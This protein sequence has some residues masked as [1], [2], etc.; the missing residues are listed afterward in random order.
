MPRRERS[1]L[2]VCF[3]AFLEV[4]DKTC[5]VVLDDLT[6]P[7]DMAGL[8]PAGEARV[9]VTTRRRDAVLTGG[10]RTMIDVGV[11]TVDEAELYLSERLG[12]FLDQLPEGALEQAA[13]LAADLGR[14]PLGMAQASA[15]IIDQAISCAEYRVR[16]ADRTH[17]L[18]ELFPAEAEADGYAKTV[19]TTW[20]LAIE[21]ANQLTPVGLAEPMARLIATLDPTGTPEAVYTSHAVRSHLADMIE[22][23][24]VS[25]ASARL[26]LRAL[27]RLSVITHDPEPAEPRAVRMHNLTGRAVLQTVDAE[28]VDILV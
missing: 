11:Y 2:P 8:W 4:T 17:K 7:G 19:A 28:H 6:S 22:Q 21:A 5:L 24:E 13:G 10:G 3:C 25:V 15:V 23:V 18:E 1:G 20:T 26:A 9:I 16:F 12:P 27:H 14:L